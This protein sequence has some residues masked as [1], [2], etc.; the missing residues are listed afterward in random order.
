MDQPERGTDIE[1]V[2]EWLRRMAI[3]YLFHVE[4]DQ[5]DRQSNIDWYAVRSGGR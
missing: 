2:E 4:M 5:P 1:S 3:K